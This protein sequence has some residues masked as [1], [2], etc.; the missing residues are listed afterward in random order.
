MA[1]KTNKVIKKPNQRASAI[2][3]AIAALTI[4][5]A[6]VFLI[7]WSKAFLF[8]GGSLLA[9][10][11]VPL[12]LGISYRL[13]SQH[14]GRRL[15]IAA[16][17]LLLC[18]VLLAG[19]VLGLV[20]NGAGG[21][22]RAEPTMVMVLG[23]QVRS[24][25]PGPMLASRLDTALDYLNANPNLPVLVSGGQGPDEHMTEAEAM[26]DYLVARGIAPERIIIEPDSHNTAQN[27]TLSKAVLESLGYDL[28]EEHILIISN[29]FHL[30]R[31]DF[32]ARRHG[33]NCSTHPA[34][35]VGGDATLRSYIREIPAVLKSF[36]LD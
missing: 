27:L 16:L 6:A 1:L 20:I 2:W 9:A 12:L 35:S 24:Y 15:R 28:A 21:T 36:L 31:A 3:L 26:R 18:A 32:L 14:T 8:V 30:Y 17:A 7:F 10:A 11:S 33:Y 29:D 22:L 34:P 25:G 23:A 4:C 19:I 5:A 13:E